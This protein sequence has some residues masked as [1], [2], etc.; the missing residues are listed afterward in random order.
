MCTRQSRC[1]SGSSRPIANDD[2]IKF[3]YVVWASSRNSDR[4]KVLAL[5][6]NAW[7]AIYDTDPLLENGHPV[8]FLHNPQYT[9][10]Q[11]VPWRPEVEARFIPLEPQPSTSKAPSSVPELPEST[12]SPQSLPAPSITKNATAEDLELPAKLIEVF[13][14]VKFDIVLSGSFPKIKDGLFPGFLEHLDQDFQNARLRVFF[15]I[16]PQ[17]IILNP[18]NVASTEISTIEIDSKDA[19]LLKEVE[20]NC[21][22]LAKDQSKCHPNRVRYICKSW[23]RQS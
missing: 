19:M 13:G 23:V 2:W 16:I 4:K 15:P 12:N 17:Y 22:H 5:Y 11:S 10:S 18:N 20:P 8:D 14:S 1:K 9:C 21:I 3:G 7:S 6:K